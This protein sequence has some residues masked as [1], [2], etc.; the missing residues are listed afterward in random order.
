MGA[1]VFR[2]MRSLWGQ[3]IS[4][5]RRKL[6]MNK[7]QKIVLECL[8]S[9]HNNYAFSTITRFIDLHLPPKTSNAY[10]HL[11][12]SEEFEVLTEFAKWGQKK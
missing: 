12:S 11:T 8:K 1:V 9:D 4:K 5:L 10:N 7:N 6:K 3:K 2:V